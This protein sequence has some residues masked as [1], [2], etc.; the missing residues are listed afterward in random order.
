[1]R[2]SKPRGWTAPVHCAFSGRSFFP[3]PERSELRKPF[4]DFTRQRRSFSHDA[5]DIERQ[6]PFDDRIRIGDKIVEDGDFS[7]SGDGRPI[8]H[9]E[10]DILIV[11]EDRDFHLA[12]CQAR[13]LD[14]GVRQLAV[15]FFCLI[16]RCRS[17]NN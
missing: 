12:S 8:R 10:R 3:S 6:Q 5:D 7:S 13:K 17:L 4:E 15:P 9:R 2:L 16:G 14:L 1:M 11:I